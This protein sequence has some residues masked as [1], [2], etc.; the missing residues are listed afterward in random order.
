MTI[1]SKTD[2]VKYVLKQIQNNKPNGMFS[3]DVKKHSAYLAILEMALEYNIDLC[4]IKTN[5]SDTRTQEVMSL[6]EFAIKNGL[7]DAKGII[8][9]YQ[10]IVPS[11]LNIT[12]KKI[13][14][15]TTNMESTMQKNYLSTLPH[16]MHD[17]L[18]QE[19]TK[20]LIGLEYKRFTH[21]NC[22]F[23]QQLQKL[24]KVIEMEKNEY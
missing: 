8:E 20:E 4:H 1:N 3:S 18:V 6:L 21:E 13:I 19:I 10:S 15:Y 23:R 17:Y 7:Q 9:T 16:E 5:F 2:C 11:L 22:A 24:Q 14:S 12:A